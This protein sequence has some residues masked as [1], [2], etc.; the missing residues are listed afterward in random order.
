MMKQQIWKNVRE[1][2]YRIKEQFIND[3]HNYDLK[4]NMIKELLTMKGRSEKP[5]DTVPALAKK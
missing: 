1:C 3:M 4:S 2:N 5:S